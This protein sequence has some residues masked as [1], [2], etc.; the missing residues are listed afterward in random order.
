M[1]TEEI[2][3]QAMPATPA[4]EDTAP[5]PYDGPTSPEPDRE[6]E[7]YGFRFNFLQFIIGVG[8]CVWYY[9][10]YGYWEVLPYLAIVVVIHEL[11]H[12]VVG[13]SFGCIVKEMQVF[14][15]EFVSYKPR[16]KASGSSWR[17]IAWSL[18]TLPL[19]GFTV[20]QNR[21]VDE[22]DEPHAHPEATAATSPYLNDKPA[23]QRLLI[24]AA[25]VLFNFATFII[26][27]V[28]MPLSAQ[29]ESM[30]WPVAF[31]SLALAVLNILPVYPLDGG[32]ILFAAYEMATGKRPSPRFTKVCAIVGFYL[33]IVFFWIFPE[34]ITAI[35]DKVL[36]LFF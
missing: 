14:L 29:W 17:N 26:L 30:C 9:S 25:G 20:F 4:S 22:S 23:W 36:A 7:E 11:G 6:P 27:Y 35:L 18:G 2:N 33:I 8:I 10:Q 21:P 15:L 28:S 31:F 24:A 1:N 19:G 3:D 34:W 5:I 13:K 32:A 12:V 16:P